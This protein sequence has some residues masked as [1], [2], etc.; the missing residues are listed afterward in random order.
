MELQFPDNDTFLIARQEAMQYGALRNMLTDCD[1]DGNPI[2]LSYGSAKFMIGLRC[3]SFWDLTLD[4]QITQ[5]E[6]A[7]Y[8]DPLDE[9]ILAT[10]LNCITQKIQGISEEQA[11]TPST[12]QTID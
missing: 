11:R 4:E 12:F 5:W 10:L 1:Y 6:F 9:K 3:V 7:N 2:K 8:L